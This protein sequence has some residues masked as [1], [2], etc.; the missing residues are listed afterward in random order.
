MQR[1]LDRWG[2]KRLR[3]VTF[4]LSGT[5][6]IWFAIALFLAIKTYLDLQRITIITM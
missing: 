6:T 5:L 4:V 1:L 2:A 3:L